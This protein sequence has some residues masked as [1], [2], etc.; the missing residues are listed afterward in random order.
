MKSPL[1]LFL[2]GSLCLASLQ[3]AQA[4]NIDI[5]V[6]ERCDDPLASENSPE[7]EALDE[8]PAG[9]ISDFRSDYAPDI[10]APPAALWSYIDLAAMFMFLTLASV[11]VLKRAKPGRVTAG[12]TLAF[13]YF[14]IFRGGCIC[15][16]GATTN[17]TLGIL[18][19]ELVGK[20]IVGLF[21]LPLFFALL[22]GRLFC[23]AACPIGAIQHL[24]GKRKPRQL[25]RVVNGLLNCLPPVILI[26]TVLMAVNRAVF[27][28]CR[29]DPYKVVFF[30]GTAWVTK[31]SSLAT[32][33]FCEPGLPLVGDWVAWLILTIF[34]LVGHWF[35]RP[36]CRVLCPYGVLLGIF[37]CVGFKQ[38]R[39]RAEA[40]VHCG[41]C[42]KACPV[43]A[44]TVDRKKNLAKLSVYSCIQCNRCNDVCRKD[45]I[46]FNA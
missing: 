5:P 6:Q 3:T 13:L 41:L 39:I 44:I 27:L 24:T 7:A 18:H 46:D 22:F 32:G 23:S 12:L 17:V 42:A 10:Y 1:L 16:V 11:M 8:D 20:L 37:A 29:L 38:R 30:S 15:P 19:P 14:G 9:L 4:Q 26:A 40:C 36:F 35:P 21:L 28:V 45:A 2:A 33:Q 25:P 43:Q 34:L 31:L